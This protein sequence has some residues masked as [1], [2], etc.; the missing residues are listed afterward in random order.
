MFVRIVSERTIFGARR[1]ICLPLPLHSFRSPGVADYRA[2]EIIIVI[3]TVQS[4]TII[5]IF[6]IFLLL[7]Y[8]RIPRDV[9]PSYYGYPVL[10][11]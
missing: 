1:G 3:F 10:N 2:F 9:S 8:R 5:I 7:T 11:I 4:N 6:V